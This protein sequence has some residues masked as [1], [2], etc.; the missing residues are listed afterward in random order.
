M[1]EALGRGLK[2]GV[3]LTGGAIVAGLLARRGLQ[4]PRG[5]DVGR[6]HAGDGAGVAGGAVDA[7]GLARRRLVTTGQTRRRR[8]GRRPGALVAR[9]ALGARGGAS[10][11]V[12]ADPA[13]RLDGAATG[14]TRAA[15]CTRAGPARTELTWKWN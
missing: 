8:D 6:R 1:T 3:A 9:R 5:A 2:R 12:L 10:G 15:H 4:L 14:V 13:G 11:A 7:G